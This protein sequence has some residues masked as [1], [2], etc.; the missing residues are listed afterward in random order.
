MSMLP[1]KN[2]TLATLLA[3][4]AG[5]LG[6]HRFYLFGKRDFWGWA[7]VATVPLALL[8]ALAQKEQP[9][10]FTAAPFVVSMLAGFLEALVIGLTADDKWDQQHNAHSGRSS[11]S[12]WPLAL[13]LVLTL[14]VGATAVIAIIARISDLLITG[15]AYG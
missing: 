12:S 11:A 2:K 5:G 8:I 4:L 15:G 13:V 1:H 3:A 10:L 14:G 6:V 7:H 9:L